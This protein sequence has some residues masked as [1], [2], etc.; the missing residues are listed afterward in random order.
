MGINMGQFPRKC[1]SC[2]NRYIFRTLN[3][4]DF[5]FSTVHTALFL[6]GKLHFEVLHLLHA[7]IA[8][9]DTR[10]GSNPSYMTL[11]RSK[12]IASNSVCRYRSPILSICS[13]R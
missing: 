12:Q 1:P 11:G 8:T 2:L 6:Y 3:A 9:F 4:I 10:P 5:L 13:V 7:S